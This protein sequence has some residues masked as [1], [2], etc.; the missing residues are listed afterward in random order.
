TRKFAVID[1]VR[2]RLVEDGAEI[3]DAEGIR[4]KTGD[5]WWLLRASSTQDALVVRGEAATPD[6]LTRLKRDLTQQLAKSGVA[7]AEGNPDAR[8]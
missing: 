4:V 2:A 1:E 5:G 8:S 6:G 3:N 7:V